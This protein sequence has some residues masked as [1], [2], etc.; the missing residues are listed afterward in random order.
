MKKFVSLE[1]CESRCITVDEGGHHIVPWFL[2]FPIRGD[3][4]ALVF[5]LLLLEPASI[6]I[7]VFRNDSNYSLLAGMVEVGSEFSVYKKFFACWRH[8]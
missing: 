1:R 8:Y 7:L 4:P 6:S 3:S 2:C 5:L